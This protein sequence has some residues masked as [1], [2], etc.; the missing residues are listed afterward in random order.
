MTGRAKDTAAGWLFL[1]PVILGILLFTLVPFCMSFYYSFTSYNGITEPKWIGL[2]NYAAL[3][4]NEDF[5]IALK[6]TGLYSVISVVLGLFFSFLLGLLMNSKVRGIKFFRVLFYMPVIMPGVASAA[7]WADMFNP[8]YVGLVNRLLKLIGL[9]PYEWFASDSLAL[10]TFIFMSLWTIG[11]GML[12]WVAGFKG[13]S[14]VYYEAADIEGAS[15]LKKLLHITLPM[16]TP[17]IF[18]NLIMNIIT[19][20][21]MFNQ[22]YIIG[23]NKT[24]KFIAVTI[25]E[26]AFGGNWRMGYA[27]AMAWILFVII[28][29]LTFIVF[30]TSKWVYYGDEP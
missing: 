21:Q 14:N 26:T 3:F 13:I 1:L 19:S 22:A 6:S 11:G 27:S 25:Y 10:P 24:T 30:K 17:I 9:G 20:L 15:G 2:A 29:A 18:Y 5:G 23:T 28:M 7:V 8:T 12:M 16:M 4:K